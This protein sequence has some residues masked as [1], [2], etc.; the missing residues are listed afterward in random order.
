MAVLYVAFAAVALWLV[1]ELLMQSRA[2]VHWRVLALLGFLCVVLGV[3]AHQALVIVVG[4]VL[5]AVGQ[6][7]VTLAVRRGDVRAW[8]AI[9]REARSPRGLGEQPGRLHVD[10][11]EE[12][13]SAPSAYP[14]YEVEQQEHTAAMPLAPA[15]D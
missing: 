14:P 10:P 3:A 4:I 1:S 9:D 7:F 11:V 5:F 2:Q 12:V 15:Y 13:S 6:T 8:V